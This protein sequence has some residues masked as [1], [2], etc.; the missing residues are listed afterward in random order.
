MNKKFLQFGLFRLRILVFL[1]LGVAVISDPVF[2]REDSLEPGTGIIRSASEIDYPPFCLVDANNEANGFSVELLRASLKAMGREVSFQTGTWEVVKGLLEKG[3]VQVLPLVGRTPEREPSFDFTFPYMTLHGAIVVRKGTRDIRNLKDLKGRTVAVMKGDNAEEFLKREDRGIL[4][5][6]TTTYYEA[7]KGLSE[8]L[9]DAVVVQRLVA[10]R[11]IQ[12]TGLNNIEIINQPVEG[13]RQD[14]CFA[15]KEGDRDMLSLLNEGLSLVMADGTYSYLHAKWFAALELPTHRRFVIGG[16]ENYPPYEYLDEKGKPAGYNVDLT[17]AIA[18]ATGLDIEIRLGP[19]AEIRDDVARGEV[20]AL[21]GL[22]Y[23]P[24]RDLTFDFTPPH[25]VN[26]CVAVIRKGEGNPP[27]SLT[28]LADQRIVVQAGDIMHDFAM[29]NGL[30][31]QLAVVDS[32]EQALL[33][34]SRGKYDCALVSRLTALYWIKKDGLKNLTVGQHPLL[35]PEYCYAVPQNHRALLAQL[36]EGLKVLD[37]SGEYRRIYEKWMGMYPDSPLD[38]VTILRNGAKIIAPL[39][40]L[41]L[42]ILLWT[43]SLRRQVAVRT[44]ELRKSEEQYR[45]LADNTMD[46]ICTLNDELGITYVNPACYPILGYSPEE[47]VGNSVEKYCDEKTFAKMVFVMKGGMVKGVKSQGTIFEVEL[48]RKDGGIVPMEIQ[49]RLIF[50]EHGKPLKIQGVARDITERK[51]AE[52]ALGHQDRLLREMGSIAKIGGWEF[53]PATGR[54]TWTEQTARIHDL[55]PKDETNVELGISF[56]QEESREKIEEAVQEAIELGKSYDLELELISAKGVHKWVRTMGKPRMENGKVVRIRG[57]FQDITERMQFRQRIEHLNRVLRAIRDVNHL[58]VHERNP[59]RL[60]EEG[61]RLLV[62]NRGYASALIIL[63]DE[64]GEIQ[65]WAQ[66]GMGPAFEAMAQR[67]SNGVLPACCAFVRETD[68]AFGI[69]DRPGKCGECPLAEPYAGLDALVIRLCHGN[70]VFGFLIASIAQGLASDPEEKSLFSEIAGDLA[71]ALHALGAEKAHEET[72]RQ[73]KSLEDQL[74]QA[75]KM[76]SVGRLAGGVA[77]DFNNMLSVI[78]GYTEIALEKALPDG[79]MIPDLIEIQKAAT[80]SA[81]ITR[82][83]LAFARQQTISPRMMDLNETVESMLKMLRRLMGEDIDL[84]WMP[85]LNLWPVNMDPSQVDQILANLVVNARDAISGVGKVIIETANVDLDEAYCADRPGFVPGEYVMLGVSDNGSG[86]DLKVQKLIFEPFFTTKEMGKGT[87][88]GLATVYGIVK[89]NN[90]FINVYSEPGAGT[91]FKIYFPRLSG[92]TLSTLDETEVA[93]A[94]PRGDETVLLVEDEVV[95]LKMGKRML[96]TLGYRVLASSSPVKALEMV[97]KHSEDL[98]IL[99][100]D[101]VMPEM[102]GR[103]LSRELKKFHPGIA[104]LFMSG[105]T[106]NVIAHQGVLDAGVYFIQK[107]F[108][109]KDLAMKVRLVLDEN[110]NG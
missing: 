38:L 100:T 94:L 93:A 83:L 90:G 28:D 54:G 58:I 67:I 86:M 103:D 104:T 105:Y 47:M 95:I 81:D 82:Q 88:L 91:T 57:S 22:F 99:I 45:L 37:E 49:G 92:K 3:E 34:L 109:K 31:D 80:R 16:D 71:Y 72:E 62:D 7:L 21:Q 1:F 66:A 19:W 98:H 63:I 70:S 107:P 32:Q 50:G 85:G 101:V 61:C 51:K 8:G 25:I 2:A 56:Y 64:K 27:A 89:Q 36:S 13:F 9:Y 52:E 29:E 96:E 11:L 59:Q 110:Q 68:Q 23:S 42:V 46:M 53:D 87:G 40:V 79:P 5:R 12:Q 84:A 43:W 78:L 60:I 10:I 97:Q 74:I 18:R 6:P 39:V 102:N 33:D 15:V 17:R 65:T 75:Q 41:L 14:F 73:R 4:I 35:S 69:E 106:A 44:E 24:E 26:H 55:D 48:I 20:D 77:H 108:S 30:K 76:E